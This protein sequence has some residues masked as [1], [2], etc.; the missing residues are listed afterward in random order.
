[1]R[2]GSGSNLKNCL[3]NNTTLC[4]RG[5]IMELRDFKKILWSYS[6][7]VWTTTDLN[8]QACLATI[9]AVSNSKNWSDNWWKL[10]EEPL[11]EQ[12]HIAWH[13]ATAVRCVSRADWLFGILEKRIE[14]FFSSSG[15][16]SF[17]GGWLAWFQAGQ[18]R[19][20]NIAYWYPVGNR[21]TTALYWLELCRVKFNMLQCSR[22]S[23]LGQH[24]C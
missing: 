18:I 7:F 14:V 23:H 2:L 16:E 21:N 5:V 11:A 1:M 8:L 9:S 13:S 22:T 24:T 15:A 3:F 19:K 10:T 6:H 4:M 20:Q 17:G 12:H